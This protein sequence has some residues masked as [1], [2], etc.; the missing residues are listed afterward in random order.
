MTGFP[1]W[2]RPTR[3]SPAMVVYVKTGRPDD[4]MRAEGAD[5]T[6]KQDVV[7]TADLRVDGRITVFLKTNTSNAVNY[8]HIIIVV[9]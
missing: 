8:P 4:A 5:F 3:P 2:Q 6:A 1:R 9:A 7:Y